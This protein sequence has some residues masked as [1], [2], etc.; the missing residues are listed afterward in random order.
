MKKHIIKK[1]ISFTLATSMLVGLSACGNKSDGKK[2]DYS[3]GASQNYNDIHN[4]VDIEYA[5]ETIQADG[6]C[7]Y[8]EPPY[9]V[10][11]NQNE[12]SVV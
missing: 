11:D 9:C 3:T 4:D 2:E 7:G 5:A 6:D 1:A 10:Y 8:N 12:Y